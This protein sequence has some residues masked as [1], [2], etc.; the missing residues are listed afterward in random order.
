M[1]QPVK[2]G[3]TTR[4][5]AARRVARGVVRDLHEAVTLT[6]AGLEGAAGRPG[7]RSAAAA[8]TP[9]SLDRRTTTAAAGHAGT[10]ATG[11]LG[12]RAVRTVT[13]ETRTTGRTVG[14]ARASCTAVPARESTASTVRRTACDARAVVT[15]LTAGATVAGRVR[16]LGRL[17]TTTTAAAAPGKHERIVTAKQAGRSTAA[18]SVGADCSAAV[19]PTVGSARTA[20]AGGRAGTADR[21]G[22]GLTRCDH[23]RRRHAGSGSPAT[24]VDVRQL[25]VATPGPE[26]LDRHL[27]DVR[28]DD[29]L[30]G[31][32]VVERHRDRHRAGRPAAR[33]QCRTQRSTREQTPPC[34]PRSS[35]R[36]AG[37]L[38]TSTVSSR[39]CAAAGEG[40][41]HDEDGRRAQVAR[42]SSP[43]RPDENRSTATRSGPATMGR[44]VRIA[45]GLTPGSFS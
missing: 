16:V 27:T 25:T 26:R 5:G 17:A 15:R 30:D 23:Q 7:A 6:R 35:L 32:D 13:A 10:A 8:S 37:N 3:S 43:V 4:T 44:S 38:A 12:A 45:P 41:L 33:E 1:T 22:E 18:T 24:E 36:H 29:E 11:G 21:H 19:A 40:R 9:G 14:R 39:E 42:G 31:S 20:V 2:L 28:G 34:S